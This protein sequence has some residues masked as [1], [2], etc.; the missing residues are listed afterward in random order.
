M[1]CGC[2]IAY[3]GTRLDGWLEVEVFGDCLYHYG[4]ERRNRGER[5]GDRREERREGERER[6]R[7]VTSSQDEQMLQR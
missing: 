6:G 4:V 2:G 7:D 5:G 3:Y 1:P